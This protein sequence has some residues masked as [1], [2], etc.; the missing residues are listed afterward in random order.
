MSNKRE[1]MPMV[2]AFID[3]MRE[4]FGKKDVDRM[5]EVGIREGGFYAA[6]NGHTVGKPLPEPQSEMSADQWLRLSAMIEAD[7]R[8]QVVKEKKA[9]A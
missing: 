2:T 6:E 3:S 4:A 8:A 5:I 1:D 9:A 7:K